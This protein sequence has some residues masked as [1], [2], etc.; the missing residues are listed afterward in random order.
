MSGAGVIVGY[1]IRES[2]RRRVFVS[3][4]S[5]RSVSSLSTLSASVRRSRSSASFT[6]GSGRRGCARLRHRRGHDAV[7]ALALRDA[8]PRR[9]A[10]R[11]S[12]PERRSGRRGARAPPAARRPAGRDGRLCYSLASEPPRPSAS[13]YVWIVFTAALLITHALGD[14]WWPDRFVRPGPRSGRR[15]RSSSSASPSSGRR[16]SPEPRTGSRSSCS[17]APGSSPASW[18]RSA[19]LSN[20]PTLDR[21]STISSWALPF[22]ALYQ[23]ALHEISAES[24]G[25]TRVALQLGPF[26]GAEAG[27]VP[28][29]STPLSTSASC[30]ALAILSFARRDL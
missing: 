4:S 12:D 24:F 17:S 29:G 15:R 8:L 7:R 11:L 14:G 5:S 13:L 28:S 20:S 19:R 22:E 9:R 23:D 1:A 27:G 25:L 18:A 16:S 10:R 26:G 21:V 2:V 30:S 6:E 3:S